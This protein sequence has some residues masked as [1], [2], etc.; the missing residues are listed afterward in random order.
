[1]RHEW[2][3]VTK[4]DNYFWS[5][6]LIILNSKV[7]FSQQQDSNNNKKKKDK[8]RREFE[9]CGFNGISMTAYPYFAYIRNEGMLSSHTI[10][11][12]NHCGSVSHACPTLGILSVKQP[13]RVTFCSL[14]ST[15]EFPALYVDLYL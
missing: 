9:A 6:L 8:W 3:T 5:T 13:R 12:T 15:K 10:S 4:S 1:M 2:P 14:S 11:A 7:T